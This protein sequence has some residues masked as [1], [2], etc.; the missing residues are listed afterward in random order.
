VVG[1]PRVMGA[2]GKHLAFHVRQD[3]VVRR[4]VAFGKGTLFPSVSQ[5]GAR[6]SLLLSPRLSSWQGRSEVE[7]HVRELEVV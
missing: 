1:K 6:V 2:G 4:A 7:L 3:R 5:T